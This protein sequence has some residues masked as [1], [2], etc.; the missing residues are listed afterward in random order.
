MG[1]CRDALLIIVS[2]GG[3]CPPVLN[4]GGRP[5]LGG[6]FRR[7][8]ANLSFIHTF[9]MGSPPGWFRTGGV[10]YLISQRARPPNSLRKVSWRKVSHS[11]FSTGRVSCT[12][13]CKL[14]QTF[15]R[16]WENS[17][18]EQIEGPDLWFLQIFAGEI[19]TLC[20]SFTCGRSLPVSY[21]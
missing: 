5:C 7:K 1:C 14:A 9:I 2:V 17:C 15:F 12:G 16:D 21:S 10:G 18:A 8:T 20:S 6:E 3:L 13:D 19:W 4:S 11:W